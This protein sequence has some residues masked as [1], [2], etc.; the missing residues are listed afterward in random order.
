MKR[1]LPIICCVLILVIIAITSLSACGDNS[2]VFTDELSQVLFTKLSRL[3]KQE[4]HL[5][6]YSVVGYYNDYRFY[7]CVRFDMYNEH[8]GVWQELDKVYEYMGTE[9]SVS[10]DETTGPEYF[11]Y[12]YNRYLKAK[13]EGENKIYSDSEINKYLSIAFAQ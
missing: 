6:V 13:E 1:K 7:Y 4:S 8:E 2:D 12:Y 11:E 9:F 5:K 10:F 3:V